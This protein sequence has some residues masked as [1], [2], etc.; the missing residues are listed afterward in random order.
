MSRIFKQG[1]RVI[2]VRDYY[3]LLENG[4]VYTVDILR[5][6]DLVC[7]KEGTHDWYADRFILA[8]PLIEALL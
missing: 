1:D 8:T 2:C 3:P 5:G 6:A 7:L 4:V